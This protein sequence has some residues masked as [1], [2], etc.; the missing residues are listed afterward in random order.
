MR[1]KFLK[2][3]EKYKGQATKVSLIV[4]FL[5]SDHIPMLIFSYIW[6][7]KQ[8]LKSVREINSKAKEIIDN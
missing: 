3:S 1:E 4:P 5:K 2:K 8:A 7:G 6:T